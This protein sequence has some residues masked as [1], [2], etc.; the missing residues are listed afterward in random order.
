MATGSHLSACCCKPILAILK[1]NISVLKLWRSRELLGGI[2][3]RWQCIADEL[4]C[5]SNICAAIHNCSAG[6]FHTKKFFRLNWAAI[7]TTLL[8]CTERLSM[9]LRCCTSAW[10]MTKLKSRDG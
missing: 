2:R 8:L 5:W 9:E 6:R 4:I 3:L 10:I 7:L 1:V